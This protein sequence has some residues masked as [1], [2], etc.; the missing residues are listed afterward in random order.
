MAVD[1]HLTCHSLSGSRYKTF[2]L[3]HTLVVDNV[4]C[5]NVIAA[6]YNHIVLC[7]EIV[8]IFS[9]ETLC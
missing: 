1:S 4:A 2:A 6:I 7:N 9:S 3:F 8:R 5:L